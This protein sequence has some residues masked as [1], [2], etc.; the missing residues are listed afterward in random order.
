MGDP[1]AS[2]AGSAGRRKPGRPHGSKDGPGVKRPKPAKP[3]VPGPDARRALGQTPEANA[4]RSASGKIAGP[5]AAAKRKALI[6]AGVYKPGP[7]VPFNKPRHYYLATKQRRAA[8]LGLP[9]VD[10]DRSLSMAVRL[11]DGG[12]DAFMRYVHLAAE[13]GDD[14]AKKFLAIWDTMR[15]WDREKQS[16]DA[17]CV[18]G[19]IDRGTFLG[20][21]TKTAFNYGCDV[22]NLVAA[23]AHPAIMERTVTSAKRLDSSIGQRD[24][25]A[26]LAHAGFLP[27]P[28]GAT[29]NIVA[30]ANAVAASNA[31]NSPSVPSFLDDMNSASAARDQVQTSVIARQIMDGDD[32]NQASAARGQ[33]R[34]GVIDA[35]VL[36]ADAG[37]DA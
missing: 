5:A 21:L 9:K 7:K 34:A 26:L 27:T 2:A 11:M 29:I 16:L 31:A 37:E 28:K 25:M 36:E 14:D 19:G 6:A 13:T 32:M 22:G 30:N 18:K 17:M 35:Q 20:T 10:Y 4:K 1:A 23:A 15:Q 12:R 33:V 3:F 8:K 24:R